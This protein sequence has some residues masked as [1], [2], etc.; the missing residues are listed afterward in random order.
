MRRQYRSSRSPRKQF[1]NSYH[2]NEVPLP[3]YNPLEDPY[4]QGFFTN[5]NVARHLEAVGFVYQARKEYPYE[6]RRL[7]N[8]NKFLRNNS[9]F[10]PPHN[11]LKN[12][13]GNL[14][15]SKSCKLDCR[16]ES[17]TTQSQLHQKMSDSQLSTSPN[18]RLPF[19]TELLSKRPSTQHSSRTGGNN[20]QE[21]P[22]GMYF[23][24]RN[25][26]SSGQASREMMI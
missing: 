20:S 25:I 5:E 9:C 11:L 26:S 2:V 24:S 12:R 17:E 18:K 22:R 16:N 13:P 15:A 14:S 19:F 23:K 1:I 10:V 21:R 7:T 6:E 4:L 3:Y 8:C